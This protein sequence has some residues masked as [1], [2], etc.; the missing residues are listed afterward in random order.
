MKKIWIVRV[1][2]II[3]LIA[4]CVLCFADFDSVHGVPREFF[5]IPT[6]K[7]IHFLMFLPY[8][9]LAFF[10]FKPH[11]TSVSRVLL[12]LLAVLAFG[13]LLAEATEII[14]GYLPYRT[15]DEADLKSDCLGLVGGT[16]LTII[17]LLLMPRKKNA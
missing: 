7:W 5:G 4:I 6:D 3:Y 11:E 9:L 13:V 17:V 12:L 8:P 14:Q 2:D 16:F 15:K 10:S 1:I